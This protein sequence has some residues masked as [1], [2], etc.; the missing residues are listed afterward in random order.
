MLTLTTLL[1]TVQK[2]D[3][4][5]LK[6]DFR[7]TFTPYVKIDESYKL[8]AKRMEIWFFH[9][10]KEFEFRQQLPSW[11]FMTQQEIIDLCLHNLFTIEYSLKE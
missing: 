10:S 8:V 3:E 7:I 5:Y 9:L 4:S 6:K 11:M 1:E 2:L